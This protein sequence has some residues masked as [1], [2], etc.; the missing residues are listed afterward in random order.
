MNKSIINREG[1]H[2]THDGFRYYVEGGRIIYGIVEL[3]DGSE[4]RM[5]QYKIL[6]TKSGE[7]FDCK[8]VMPLARYYNLTRYGWRPSIGGD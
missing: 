3:D 1:W 8:R 2:V 6:R 7:V 5:Y 4:L